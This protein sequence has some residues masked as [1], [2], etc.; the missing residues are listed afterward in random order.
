MSY[1]V[2]TSGTQAAPRGNRV[3]P[4]TSRQR[5]SRPVDPRRAP[6]VWPTAPTKIAREVME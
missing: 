2:A 4:G 1:A 6:C 3:R 5:R